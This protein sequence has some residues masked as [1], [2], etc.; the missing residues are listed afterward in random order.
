LQSAELVADDQRFNARGSVLIEV[1]RRLVAGLLRLRK[2][3]SEY[4]VL[5]QRARLITN[6]FRGQP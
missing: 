4:I 1:V 6:L 3:L 2:P 5:S